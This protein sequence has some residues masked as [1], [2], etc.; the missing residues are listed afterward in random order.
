MTQRLI[1]I[2][3]QMTEIKRVLDEPD[4]KFVEML[5]SAVDT[6]DQLSSKLTDVLSIMSGF[7]RMG[8]SD[9]QLIDITKTA[10]VLQN[11]SDLDQNS[12]VDTL[13]SAMLNFNIAA[14]DSLTISD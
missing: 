13:T 6:S 14:K 11:I 7:S 10:Q 8:F 1:Q 2:D 4:Y 12:S 3:S 9:S 5:Q